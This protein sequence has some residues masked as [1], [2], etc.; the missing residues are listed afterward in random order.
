LILKM[1]RQTLEPEFING[2]LF[3]LSQT[4]WTNTPTKEKLPLTDTHWPQLSLILKLTWEISAADAKVSN[5]S[6]SE[7]QAQHI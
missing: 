1:P 5:I 2:K 3:R 6:P 4:P 7:P